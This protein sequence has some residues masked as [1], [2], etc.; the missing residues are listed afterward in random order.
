MSFVLA[1]ILGGILYILWKI[2]EKLDRI[3]KDLTRILR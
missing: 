2:S 1:G 3:Q